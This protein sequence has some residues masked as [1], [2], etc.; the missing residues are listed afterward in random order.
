MTKKILITILLAIALWFVAGEALAAYTM[1]D[2]MKPSNLPSFE[3]PTATEGAPA[4]ATATQA[5]IL[6]VGNIVSQVLLFAG[7]IAI[8]FL[9][10]AG[11]NYILAFGKDEKI[12]KGKRGIFWVL[13]GLLIILLSYSIV[14]AIMALILTTD[15]NA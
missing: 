3:L 12:E 7:A 15:V 10:L 1:D 6:F 5:L 13:I 4:E 11:S 2:S 8:I 14:R 9:I